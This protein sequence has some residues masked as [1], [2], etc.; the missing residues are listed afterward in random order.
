MIRNLF[1]P[2]A[3]IQKRF[4]PFYYFSFSKSNKQ[5]K[6][7]YQLI[8]K[9]Q[10][11]DKLVEYWD[12]K[13]SQP[14]QN[15]VSIQKV[16]Q[17]IHLAE[18]LIG[19]ELQ[20]K[21]WEFFEEMF[22]KNFI[23]RLYI[24]KQYPQKIQLILNISM[25]LSLLEYQYRLNRR[26][27]LQLEQ[28][29][30]R[31]KGI[32]ENIYNFESKISDLGE[33]EFNNLLRQSQYFDM[34]AFYQKTLNPEG[35]VQ[36]LEESTK[37]LDQA[38]KIV[39]DII[40]HKENVEQ[41]KYQVGKQQAMSKIARNFE[42]LAEFL[43]ISGQEEEA[44]SFLEKSL[45]IYET[46]ASGITPKSILCQCRIARSY[47]RE[48][49]EKSCQLISQLYDEISQYGE[50]EFLLL[51]QMYKFVILSQ[52]E[53]DEAEYEKLFESMKNFRV[54][55]PYIISEVLYLSLEYTFK[56]GY[57]KAL[58]E[59]LHQALIL[60]ENSSEK[61]NLE[62]LL[63]LTAQVII[64][65]PADIKDQQSLLKVVYENFEKFRNRI[66]DAYFQDHL[67]LKALI[68]A[69]LLQFD[70][71]GPEII[72]KPILQF[73][74]QAQ[75]GKEPQFLNHIKQIQRFLEKNG[76]IFAKKQ[77]EDLSSQK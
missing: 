65:L 61:I 53:V 38:V 4:Q 70:K 6:E 54:T 74:E 68:K 50:S 28:V 48:N 5:E 36:F 19:S 43:L 27:I 14:K 21:N 33:A 31:I 24:P 66:D 69:K 1:R 45:E 59:H 72:I 15:S 18:N 37:C 49:Y 63:H 22:D 67:L 56:Q 39:N 16:L 7:T 10:E 17:K 11:F 32:L 12:S 40:K 20:D 34:K 25:E 23:E 60:I 44:R 26:E 13:L 30:E 3:L 8:L 77:I 62:Q 29:L 9:N 73:I 41:I 42:I 2:L 58:S 51:V 64:E 52:K 71:E 55:D 76:L 57:S 47:L 75:N 35:Y 46:F